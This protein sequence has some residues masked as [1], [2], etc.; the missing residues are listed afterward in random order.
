M[1]RDYGISEARKYDNQRLR[2][3]EATAPWKALAAALHSILL[4]S[5]HNLTTEIDKILGTF[6]GG[7]CAETWPKNVKHGYIVE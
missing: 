2:D 5:L 7:S 1:V 4:A 6:T 3:L